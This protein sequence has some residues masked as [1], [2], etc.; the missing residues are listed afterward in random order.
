M[1]CRLP[2]ET[3]AFIL[4]NMG[5]CSMAASSP[6]EKKHTTRPLRIAEARIIAMARSDGCK[7]IV[8]ERV[9]QRCWKPAEG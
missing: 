7:R 1:I 2:K 8:D 6:K 4:V 9:A 5:Y 3:R